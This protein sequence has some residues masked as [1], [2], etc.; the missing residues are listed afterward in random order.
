[1]QSATISLQDRLAGID[2]KTGLPQ[3]LY[4]LELLRFIC[5]FTIVW[6][7]MHAPFPYIGYAGLDAFIILSVGLS[8]RSSRHYSLKSFMVR[9]VVR[10]LIPWLIWS[11]FYLTLRGMTQGPATVFQLNQP[12]W[13][14]IGPMIHLWFLPF[15]LLSAPLMYLATHM[16]HGRYHGSLL[17]LVLVPL[18]SL[19]LY[20]ERTLALPEP[21][22]QWAFAFP[23]LAY[24][25]TRASGRAV[26]PLAI[27]VGTW[28]TTYLLG[29]ATPVIFLALAALAFELALLLRGIGSWAKY[30][31]NTA[32]GIYLIHPFCI[33]VLARYIDYQTQRV[34]LTLAVFALSFVLSLV[35]HHGGGALI[36]LYNRF[37]A[38][39][40]P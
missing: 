11:G 29:H 22:I 8:T 13:L 6:G 30:L 37:F 19:A 38:R 24:G 32:F 7:H 9:R 12:L 3:P 25:V 21:F 23:A 18:C 10:I 31:G 4:G 27:V 36:H 5:A 26:T 2:P 33:L 28:V 20:L 14:L 15:L 35:L 1:M 16:P 17:I 40:A 34:P 39:Q